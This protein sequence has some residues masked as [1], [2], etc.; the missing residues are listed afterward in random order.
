MPLLAIVRIES[1]PAAA[2]Q[3][4]ASLAK[5]T[6][7]DARMRLAAGLPAV[8]AR[9]DA[10]VAATAVETLAAS[11]VGAVVVDDPIPSRSNRLCAQTIGLGAGVVK[12]TSRSGE[13]RLMK[14]EEIWLILRGVRSSSSTTKTTEKV[15]RPAMKGGVRTESVSKSSTKEQLENLVLIYTGDGACIEI[16]E[17]EMQWTSLGDKR[18][19]SGPANVTWI[20]GELQRRAP[21]ARY[22]DSLVQLGRRTLPFVGASES[23][24]KVDRSDTVDVIAAVLHRA[25]VLGL[26]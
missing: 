7:Y 1:D 17:Q 26:L 10:V 24:S 14:D 3:A 5:C 8:V 22:D 20:A 21:K 2:T 4:I 19:L 16:A 23:A 13:S 11:K 9:I 12:Y 15:A 6:A 18:Q 25:C